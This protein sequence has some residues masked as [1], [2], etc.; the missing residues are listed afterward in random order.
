[1]IGGKLERDYVSVKEHWNYV[2]K[3][4]L[5]RHHAGTAHVDIREALI[6]YLVENNMKYA[7]DV[8]W[9]EVAKLPEFVGTTPSYLQMTYRSMKQNTGAK[10]ERMSKVELTTEAVQSYRE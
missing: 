9:K 8:D 5:L 10:Y 1:M 3:P 6:N 4:M 7:Q 2:L